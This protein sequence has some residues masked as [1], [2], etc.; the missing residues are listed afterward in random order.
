MLLII[1]NLIMDKITVIY[2]PERLKLTFFRNGR[3]I[4]GL[5]GQIAEQRF[6]AIKQEVERIDIL[7]TIT[8][9]HETKAE[10]V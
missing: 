6:L 5:V 9:G 3:M 7:K 10:K 8:N 4:G 2:M 1:K